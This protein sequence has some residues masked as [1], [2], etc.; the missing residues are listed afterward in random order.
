MENAHMSA[1]ISLADDPIYAAIRKYKRAIA[2]L[3]A[4][5]GRDL[6]EEGR[7]E[8]ASFDAQDEFWRVIPRTPEGVRAKINA[9]LAERS[10]GE[11]KEALKAFL[12]TLH[13]ATVL[14]S[15]RA[16]SHDRPR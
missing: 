15:E 10:G 1:V 5:H 4:Y 13:A 11:S 16:C 7:L 3:N 9:F 2:V 14:I 6:A 8:Q 12:D